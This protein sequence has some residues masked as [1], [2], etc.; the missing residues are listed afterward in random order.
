MTTNTYIYTKN[1]CYDS[2]IY[3]SCEVGDIIWLPT[4]D[5]Y[6][7][8]TKYIDG[9]IYKC[10]MAII[11]EFLYDMVN[12]LKPYEIPIIVT[13]F[14]VN[15]NNTYKIG[16][17]GTYTSQIINNLTF[18]LHHKAIV[19]SVKKIENAF[20]R[21]K[22]KKNAVKIIEKFYIEHI[23]HPNHPYI[24]KKLQNLKNI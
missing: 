21:Y 19:N 11:K 14:N 16:D 1:V 5:E 2:T 24:I 6:K 20:I 4:V 10:N 15:E 12:P 8:N 18:T 7:N 3:E 23:L 17:Y 13:C 9:K 22:N